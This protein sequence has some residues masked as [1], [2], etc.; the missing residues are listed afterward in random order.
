MFAESWSWVFLAKM[1][2]VFK[3][4]PSVLLESGSSNCHQNLKRAANGETADPTASNNLLSASISITDPEA[5][6]A[7]LT[8]LIYID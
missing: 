3:D 7:V 6:I 5:V 1:Q 2:V 8:K 4:M